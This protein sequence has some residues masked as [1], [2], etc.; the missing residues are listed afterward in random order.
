MTAALGQA[1]LFGQGTLFADGAEWTGDP[2][3]PDIIPADRD[4]LGPVDELDRCRETDACLC[5]ECYRRK[6][7]EQAASVNRQRALAAE[8]HADVIAHR[9]ECGN[10]IPGH[11]CRAGKD[12][13]RDVRQALTLLSAMERGDI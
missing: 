3:G 12:A 5:G 11:L 8:R 10:C 7:G 13:E 1:S 6:F 2:G 4:E 9:R